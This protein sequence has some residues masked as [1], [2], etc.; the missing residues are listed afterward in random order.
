MLNVNFEMQFSVGLAYFTWVH[1]ALSGVQE[2][3]K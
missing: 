3:N 1:S 2:A